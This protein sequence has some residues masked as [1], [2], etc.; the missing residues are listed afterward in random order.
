VSIELLRLARQDF[1][2]GVQQIGFSKRFIE[3]VHSALFERPSVR[4]LIFM[5]TDNDDDSA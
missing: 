3:N 5:G 2:D 1:L 4:V